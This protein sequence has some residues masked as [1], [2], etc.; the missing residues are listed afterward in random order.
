MVVDILKK[1][2]KLKTAL[3]KKPTKS[4]WISQNFAKLYEGCLIH[5]ILQNPE[6]LAKF[7]NMVTNNVVVNVKVGFIGDP[8]RYITRSCLHF[9]VM[10]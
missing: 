8:R 5:S 7:P 10:R 2:K 1:N 9:D 4:T 3:Q 6:N